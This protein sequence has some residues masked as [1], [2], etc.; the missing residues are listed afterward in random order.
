ML[1]SNT[2]GQ[3]DQGTRGPEDRGT[4]GPE[5][6]GTG[7]PGDQRTKKKKMPKKK[8]KK[9][10]K[11]VRTLSILFPW[12]DIPF[13]S[14]NSMFSVFACLY[15]PLDT[16]LFTYLKRPCPVMA[17]SSRSLALSE[18]SKHFDASTFSDDESCIA[19]C[20][21]RAKRFHPKS[22]AEANSKKQQFEMRHILE[23]F[24][25]MSSPQCMDSTVQWDN[26]RCP[27]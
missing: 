9:F 2:R 16:V 7:G 4:R 6:Q 23:C 14:R 21:A 10:P 15:V 3:E 25:I 24:G 12:M 19:G 22:A 8:R 13:N 20:S 18:C 1:I 26:Q 5:D 17:A 27:K 11:Q